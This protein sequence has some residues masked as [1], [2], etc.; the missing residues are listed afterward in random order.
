VLVQTD[1]GAFL[2]GSGNIYNLEGTSAFT[3]Q[4]SSPAAVGTVVL[5]VRT[6]GSEL[7]YGSPSL[8]YSNDMGA[9][10]VAPLPRVELDRS[11]VPGLGAMV[12]SLWQWDLSGHAALADSSSESDTASD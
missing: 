4:D 7:D 9:V 6:I 3:L 12:S 2:T 11:N 10:Q 5:Q 8:T 1:E